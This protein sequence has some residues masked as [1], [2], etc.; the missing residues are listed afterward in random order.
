MGYLCSVMFNILNKWKLSSVFTFVF[1]SIYPARTEDELYELTDLFYHPLP[2][3]A[4][5]HS[6]INYVSDQNITYRFISW[7]QALFLSLKIFIYPLKVGWPLYWNRNIYIL[8]CFQMIFWHAILCSMYLVK[9]FNAEITLS[10]MQTQ[11]TY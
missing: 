2:C 8:L 6:S 1:F 9:T 5:D 7:K 11:S 4:T 3:S 10:W